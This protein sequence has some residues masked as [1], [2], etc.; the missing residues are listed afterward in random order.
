MGDFEKVDTIS[1]F[2][3]TKQPRMMDISFLSG[4]KRRRSAARSFLFMSVFS[5]RADAALCFSV[6]YQKN[7]TGVLYGAG[8]GCSFSF[9]RL[10]ECVSGWLWRVSP[11]HLSYA[12]VFVHGFIGAMQGVVHGTVKLGV[13]YGDSHRHPGLIP[14]VCGVGAFLLRY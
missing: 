14:F 10:L 1:L 13:M 5:F 11:F 7:M 12:L 3:F 9:D 2:S 8:Q 4:L 6:F